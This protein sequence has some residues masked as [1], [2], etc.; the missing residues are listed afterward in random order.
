M[1]TYYLFQT[2]LR[3]NGKILDVY[4]SYYSRIISEMVYLKSII[5]EINVQPDPTKLSDGYD[6]LL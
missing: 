2:F 1:S 4:T 6:P 3:L 5:I